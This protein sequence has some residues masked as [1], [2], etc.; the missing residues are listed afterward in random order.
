MQQNLAVRTDSQTLSTRIVKRV[1]LRA[2][3]LLVALEREAQRRLKPLLGK[4]PFVSRREIRR[5]SVR[6]DRLERRLRS[7]RDPSVSRTLLSL[8]APKDRYVDV[9]L[10]DQAFTAE[11]EQTLKQNL[12]ADEELTLRMRFGLGDGLRGAS[13]ARAIVRSIE[14][15]ALIKLWQ[16]GYKAGG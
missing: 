7:H 4:L 9:L 12:T 15:R 2:G 16:S 8:S 1:E 14:R 5:L 11:V 3:S 13:P 10:A 6:I